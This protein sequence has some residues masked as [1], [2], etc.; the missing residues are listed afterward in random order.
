MKIALAKLTS[1]I[2]APFRKHFVLFMLCFV[3][4]SICDVIMRLHEYNFIFSVLFAGIIYI[5]TYFLFL[6]MEILPSKLQGFYK[7]IILSIASFNAFVD[8]ICLK[9]MNGA[10]F[11]E[12]LGVIAGTN[13]QEIVEFIRVFLS[14]DL[15]FIIIAFGFVVVILLWLFRKLKNYCTIICRLSLFMMIVEML[16]LSLNG[17]IFYFEDCYL[18]KIYK[19]LTLE[20]APNLKYYYS[21]PVLV[22]TS[23]D[24]P[25][26]IVV[27][28][29]ESFSK[30]H[31]SLYG[32]EK[33]TNPM[34]EKLRN[35]SSLFVFDDVSCA[36]IQTVPNIKCI[37]STFTHKN[38]SIEWY[39]CITLPEILQKAEYKTFWISNQSEKGLWD[40]V[41]TKYAEL[42][43]SVVF[44][45]SKYGGFDKVPYDAEV[46]NPLKNI[47]YQ[48]KAGK[49]VFFIHLMGSHQEFSSRYPKKF[50][51]YSS[52]DYPQAKEKQRN[53]LAHYDNSVLY[54]DKV[55]S[56][57]FQIF[58]N[59]ECVGFYFSDHSLDIFNTD[60]DYAGHARP[61]N[62]L[63][64]SISTKVPFM[65]FLSDSCKT[66]RNTLLE[67]ILKNKNTEFNTENFIYLLM[68]VIGVDFE[69]ESANRRTLLK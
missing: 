31:S 17:K 40:N 32:Y 44:V 41:T 6:L 65:M 28:I 24:K 15:L 67:R 14:W 58:K 34:L 53:V 4:A 33:K 2:E 60:D 21:H 45:G 57:I 52:S 13:K 37:M 22:S 66:T 62:S 50:E 19:I 12:F 39:E 55:V 69:D 23:N 26:N 42:C 51:K 48:N 10:A 16:L 63:S 46:L 8:L 9:V 38:D 64:V 47:F 11:T 49:N 54:N 56:D 68:D 30:E 29:G 35:D 25:Q 61:N 18:G 43:D 5:M 3:I 59:T 7:V 36:E 1:L 27:V 20:R